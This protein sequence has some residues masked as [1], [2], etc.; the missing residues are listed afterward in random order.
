[1]PRTKLI[2]VSFKYIVNQ[3]F[4]NG[5]K[6]KR[7]YNIILLASILTLA[8]IASASTVKIASA[9]GHPGPYL[10]VELS[11]ATI[12][13]SPA[14][15]QT[16]NVTVKLYNVTQT[17]VPAGVGGCE[18]H[19]TWNTTLIE[20]VSFTNE[21]ATSH[22]VLTGSTIYAVPPGFY[23]DA[24]NPI[25]GPSYTNAT[26]YNVA[27][28]ATSG[29]AWWGNGAEVAELMFKVDLQP[30]PFATCPIQLSSTDL[31]DLS[32]NEI[33]H[34]AV[35]ANLTITT[36]TT[37]PETVTYNGVNYTVSIASDSIVTAPAN[38]GFTNASITFNVTSP[39]G[40]CNVTFPNN[41]MWD[42]SLAGWTIT[43]DGSPVTSP[44]ATLTADSSNSYVWF[45]FTAG[46]HV[47]VIQSVSAV[48]EFGTTSLLLLLMA[49]TLIAT[50]TAT[51]LRRRKLYR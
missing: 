44:N 35:N 5:E 31:V 25:S 27:A 10:T 47:I 45:N 1:L 6:M 21:I 14:I 42:S 29:V 43:V 24:G 23:D 3:Y 28:A 20:P 37:T 9:Q 50:A 16:F 49:T 19:L 33:P 30:L 51:S 38:L 7:I 41:F 8:V 39:D 17:N 13:P 40:F 4:E 22:G 26:H 2:L 15:G 36:T 48:P 32:E 12:G 11:Q 18:I 46:N 34:D